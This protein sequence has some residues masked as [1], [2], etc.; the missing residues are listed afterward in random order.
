M[1]QNTQKDKNKPR[2]NQV[3]GRQMMP[4]IIVLVI[5]PIFLMFLR[6]SGESVKELTV[7]RF[8]E[9]LKRNLIVSV[10]AEQQEGG[11][12]VVLT[13][14]YQPDS[15]S[16]P[17]PYRTKVLYTDAV[18]KLIREN[19]N[20]RDV[21]S[22]HSVFMNILMSVLPFLIISVILYI[23][24]ARQ[25]QATGRSAMLFGKSRAKKMDD[26][27]NPVR[28]KDVAGISEAKEEVQEIVDYLKDP[29]KF[30]RLGGRIPHG[31]LM[32]GP[33]GTGK[34]LLARAI[35]GEANVPFYS[36]SGSDFVELFVG[37]GASR[38]RDMFDEGKRNAPCLIFID[39]IDAVGAPVSQ[40]LAAGMT[41]ASRR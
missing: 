39:E 11:G 14:N 28:F 16:A 29:K 23:F 9:L 37:V 30:Q 24:F 34:T 35:A 36:I 31:V 21:K 27:K 1:S 13:G 32:V 19:A 40:A 8:E 4:W 18:D 22:G 5:V 7:S 10:I 6:G 12:V 20:V 3:L 15:N 17:Q 41:S 38:V 26:A 25:M 2:G 33:P